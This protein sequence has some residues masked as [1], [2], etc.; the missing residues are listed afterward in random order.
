MK[1]LRKFLDEREFTIG[2]NNYNHLA[3]WDYK[4]RCR[5][6]DDEVDG[7]DMILILDGTMARPDPSSNAEIIKSW[8]IKD[9][10]VRR[11]LLG[12]VDETLYHITTGA[13]VATAHEM[14]KA[15]RRS[16]LAVVGGEDLDNLLVQ[17]K[18]Y[19]QTNDVTGWTSK[20]E[21]YLRIKQ[22]K[23]G[24]YN[25]AARMAGR[26]ELDE[27]AQIRDLVKG[28]ENGIWLMF[29]STWD[30]VPPGK[31]LANFLDEVRLV[32]TN[33]LDGKP[34][35]V[36]KVQP[37][38]T[39]KGDKY[40]QESE[41]KSHKS[42]GL[43]GKWDRDSRQTS[44]KRKSPNGPRA[45]QIDDGSTRDLSNVRCH[46][47][48]KLGHISKTCKSTCERSKCFVE[49]CKNENTKPDHSSAMVAKDTAHWGCALMSRTYAELVAQPN[50]VFMAPLDNG[51][52]MTGFPSKDWF[53][54]ESL[55]DAEGVGVE[56][57]DG[58]I[59]KPEKKGLGVFR[60]GNPQTGKYIL[61]SMPDSYLQPNYTDP[62]IAQRKLGKLPNISILMKDKEEDPHQPYLIKYKGQEFTRLYP[63][64]DKL[65]YC[66]I[67]KASPEEKQQALEV[68]KG[69]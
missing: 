2:L 5:I 14:Y 28:L 62:V 7:D 51:S 8:E 33:R 54:E 44:D 49:Q 35:F 65:Y 9:R 12:R 10:K 26:P 56:A 23:I 17:M 27:K 63:A 58:R 29:K 60:L 45:N 6:M 64:K 55:V 19:K 25:V 38:L 50:K 48:G 57:I 52:T 21:D 61:L 39:R 13:R 30:P 1:M 24:F 22:D 36:C 47:C 18:S 66:S 37:T 69:H 68:W 59:V 15:I 42:K 32:N 46:H 4:L 34:D 16:I 40:E 3:K 11:I 31:T 20:L 41:E 53:V 67:M 43:K